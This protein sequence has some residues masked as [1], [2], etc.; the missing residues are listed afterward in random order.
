MSSLEH[1]QPHPSRE[2]SF[3]AKDVQAILRDRG[4]LG[5]DPSSEQLGF[6]E[7]AAAL[8][9]P[10]AADAH[11]L[12]ELLQLVFHYDARDVLQTIEAHTVLARYGARDVV[13]ET[14]LFLL[15]PVS[16]DSDRFKELVTLLKEKL[17]LR[18]RDLFHPLRLAL[19][20]RA[21]EGEL[22]RVILLLDEAAVLPFAV[23]VKSTRVRILEFCATLD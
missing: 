16:F 5:G 17:A 20:G 1:V 4:W 23:L 10:H 9:G 15:D 6:C 18:G 11:G 8:L 21:G 22:D 14:A 13:R 19:A 12:Q 2:N 3:T 7:H